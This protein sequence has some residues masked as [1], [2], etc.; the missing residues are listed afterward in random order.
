MT[1]PTS[2]GALRSIAVAWQIKLAPMTNVMSGLR[3]RRRGL[4]LVSLMAP[5]VYACPP[6][7]VIAYADEPP[8]P[9]RRAQAVRWQDFQTK[10]L[11]KFAPDLFGQRFFQSLVLLGS[12]DGHLKPRYHT[13]AT[14]EMKA[15]FPR[16]IEV[17]PT[18][19]A[20]LSRPLIPRKRR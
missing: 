12:P 8:N 10:S 16:H 15:N 2:S 3:W 11:K 4:A 6:K 19:P 14:S 7:R 18:C 9:A 20:P 17:A 1:A 5:R 13:S